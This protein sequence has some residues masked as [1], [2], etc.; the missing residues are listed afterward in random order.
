MKKTIV[1][2]VTGS[3][4]NFQNSLNACI[5]VHEEDG[6]EVVD[7][8][9]SVSVSTST[10]NMTFDGDYAEVYSAII[11]HRITETELTPSDSASEV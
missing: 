7:I 3:V 9:H 1:S 6:Y 8:K 10:G 2:H 4:D 11:I 5:E